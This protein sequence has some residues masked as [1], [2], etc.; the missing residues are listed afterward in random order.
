LKERKSFQES[1]D[2]Y[3]AL[4]SLRFYEENEISVKDF[5]LI[6]EVGLIYPVFIELD[7]K[8]QET[9][10]KFTSII[11]S[12]LDRWKKKIELLKI[13]SDLED[14]IVNVRVYKNN[15]SIFGVMF[16]KN[17]GHIP[18]ED[19]EKFYDYETGIIK[20]KEGILEAVIF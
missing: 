15:A 16:D 3:N 6:N 9:W 12:D 1:E 2:I 11:N 7:Q 13:K 8:A 5:N 10:K 18:K 14:Y 20:D 4:L 17:L 19:V